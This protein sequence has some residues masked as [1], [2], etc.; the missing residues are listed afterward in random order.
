MTARCVCGERIERI[1]DGWGII[2]AA[3]ADLRGRWVHV[4]NGMVRCAHG[5]SVAR[6]ANRT[7]ARP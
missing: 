3:V 2:P 6:P 7:E 1:G 4:G 5:G